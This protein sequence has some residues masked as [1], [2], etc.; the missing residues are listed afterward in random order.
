[1]HVTQRYPTLA[2]LG[3][4]AVLT[5]SAC[6]TDQAG[7]GAAGGTGSTTSS[8][9][10]TP[11]AGRKGDVMFAQMMIP[12]HQQAVEMADRALQNGASPA[13][14]EL[15]Q[16]IKAAQGPEIETM[17]TWLQEWRAPMTAEE[18]HGGHDGGAGMM[19]DGDMKDLSAASGPTFNEMWLTMMVEHHEGAVVMAQDVLTTTGNPEVKELAQAIVA[20]QK[21]EIATM[22]S[23]IS[24]TS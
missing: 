12:H 10:E 5:L 1:M 16:Q 7:S 24:G 8:T 4:A 23:L 9:S 11:E 14:T 18:G 19:A 15:A 22:T 17:T 20:G 3:I 13:V 2:G 21:Q 6:G